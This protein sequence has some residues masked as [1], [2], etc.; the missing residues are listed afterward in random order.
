VP[1]VPQVPGPAYPPGMSPSLTQYPTAPMAGRL[2]TGQPLTGQALPST[3][4][5]P[6]PILRV[7]GPAT[8]GVER[9]GNGSGVAGVTMAP[10][11]QATSP[12][13]PGGPHP[14]PQM[15]PVPLPQG[16][17]NPFAV[18]QAQAFTPAAPA[19]TP[20]TV[21]VTGPQGYLP[22]LGFFGIPGAPGQPSLPGPQSAPYV[23][24]TP[25]PV[26]PY[27]FPVLPGAQ[28]APAAQAPVPA[29]PVPA[30]PT[31]TGF[32][33]SPFW[34]HLAWQLLATP[35][36]KSALGSQ[37][38]QRTEGPERWQTLQ[39]ATACLGSQ[40]LQAAFRALTS[41]TMDQAEFTRRF[42]AQLQQA[43][44]GVTPPG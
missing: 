29:P 3:Y 12:A 32:H 33:Q 43:L 44:A 14:L 17:P 5:A 31:G 10:I 36:V 2:A 42:A 28:P 34:H 11:T 4:A 25:L 7:P 23:P 20:G 35:A 40:E 22:G 21:A 37:Y 8:L 26:A 38:A 13:Q 30:A 15:P 18:T 27:A 24:T 16:F 9:T 19:P 1:G 41:G 6:P 39:I